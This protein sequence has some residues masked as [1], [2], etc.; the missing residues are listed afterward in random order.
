MLASSVVRTRLRWSWKAALCAMAALLLAA[1]ASTAHH[2]AST[3]RPQVV[4]VPQL[5]S[6][7]QR[8]ES[9]YTLMSEIDGS[10]TVYRLTPQQRADLRAVGMPA[11][12]LGHMQA[13]YDRAVQ[14]HPELATSDDDWIKIGD[15]WYGGLPAGWPREWLTG[16]PAGGLRRP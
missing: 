9:I 5:A 8:G 11:T 1:C 4:T 15:Y 6:Q 16:P 3:G 13:T 14:S 2:T 7:V 10:G 12:L